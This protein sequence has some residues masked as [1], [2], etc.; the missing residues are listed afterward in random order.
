MLMAYS[1]DSFPS[2]YVPTVYDN[3]T[4]TVIVDNTATDVALWDTAGQEEYDRL[5][6]LAY[7]GTDVFLVCFSIVH[8]SSYQNVQTKVTFTM[9]L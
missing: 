3:Y 1:T 8:P 6:P 9:V 7:P 4:V 5:R 2:N